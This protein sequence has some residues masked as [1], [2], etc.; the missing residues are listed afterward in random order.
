M[1]KELEIA[2]LRRLAVAEDAGHPVTHAQLGREVQGSTFEDLW[3]Q[4]EI[5]I[6]GQSDLVQFCK[7][8]SEYIVTK[9]GRKRLSRHDVAQQ[10]QASD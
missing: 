7:S 6:R 4:G 8:S 2:M 9:L 1:F 5:S 10:Q 3:A